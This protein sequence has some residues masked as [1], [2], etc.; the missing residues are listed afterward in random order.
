MR[1]PKV[2][3][4][5]A[6]SVIAS[7][8]LFT[9]PSREEKVN[10]RSQPPA[11]EATMNQSIAFVP[12]AF[13]VGVISSEPIPPEE[14]IILKLTHKE[15]QDVVKL[16]EIFEKYKINELN[17][18]WINKLVQLTHNDYDGAYNDS[19][20]VEKLY[21]KS[22]GR[23]KFSEDETAQ[24]VFRKKLHDQLVDGF[25]EFGVEENTANSGS[26]P[27]NAP[28]QKE[29]LTVAVLK[30]IS[31]YAKTIRRGVERELPPGKM[32]IFPRGTSRGML[33]HIRSG[34]EGLPPGVKVVDCPQPEEALTQQKTN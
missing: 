8:A 3:L 6:A 18:S 26:E 22:I 20:F 1:T 10:P 24:R 19:N 29:D 5:T 28:K 4:G 27:D 13:S 12:P 21:L 17:Y 23:E 11:R 2:V 14:K 33:T 32:V 30:D 16:K 7:L 9:R 31:N 25:K 34:K 15:M